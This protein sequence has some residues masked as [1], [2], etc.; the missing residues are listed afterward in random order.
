MYKT[1]EAKVNA[2][3]EEI[4]LMQGGSQRAFRILGLESRFVRL[5]GFFLGLS[6][7]GFCRALRV[8]DV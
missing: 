7:K 8:K 6:F 4:I 2:I 3:V 5:E 1:E